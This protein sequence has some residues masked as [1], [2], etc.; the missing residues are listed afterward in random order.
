MSTGLRVERPQA[1]AAVI[2]VRRRDDAE[3]VAAGARRQPGVVRL[4]ERLPKQRVDPAEAVGRKPPLAAPRATAAHDA[5]GRGR[6]GDQILCGAALGAVAKVGEIPREP[7]ELE[8]ERE[9]ER[10]EHV[11]AL[12][13]RVVQDVQEARQR[14][15]RPLVALLLAEEAKHRLEPDEAHARDGTDPRA[16][17]GATG[18]GRRR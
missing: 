9:A 1:K 18:S 2:L 6:V 10:V 16:P 12:G 13:R 3:R 4:G 15:E 5:A 8:L 17:P 11:V 7:E 14:L